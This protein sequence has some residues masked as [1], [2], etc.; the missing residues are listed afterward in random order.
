MEAPTYSSKQVAEMLGVSPKAIPEDA[1]KDVYTPDDV[2]DLRTT[3]NRFPDKIGH[4]R[5]LF[6]NFK[7]GT[8][9]TSLSTSYA[10]RIAELGYSVLLIDLD[11]QG[12]A[13][14]CLG[15]EGEEFEKTL[16][17]VLVRK[18]PLVQVIQKSSLPNLDFVPSNLSMSTMDLSLMPM[19][20]REFKLRNALKDVEAQYDV[21][22]F[23]APPSFGLLNLN[24]LMAAND[25]FV[26]VLADFLSFHGL[27]L[28]FETVQSLEEDLN[29]VLDHVF[30]VVNSFNATFKLAKEALEAL[31]THYPEF[32]LPTIIRQCTKFAQASSEGRPVF[33][34]DPTS[35]GANDIQAMIDNVLPR[36]VAAAAAAPKKG[37]Q[38]AG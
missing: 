25:L 1:R 10:W 33:V 31:Q 19:A 18:T 14:K 34:A 24:A 17:D 6:L 7:G 12:H 16:L 15:Y 37:T 23:D 22:V 32:L 4:R 29:H 26:P 30:I 9:K 28:L 21:V 20:G 11:S 36:L 27:K 5:Q 13:T 2:W 38:Q 35:K 3:L 8:G